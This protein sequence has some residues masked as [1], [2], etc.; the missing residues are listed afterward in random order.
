MGWFTPKMPQN[1]TP[2][3]TSGSTP[4]SST[5][6]SGGWRDRTPKAGSSASRVTVGDDQTVS[7]VT[8]GGNRRVGGWRDRG[9]PEAS[10]SV[11]AGKG[12]RVTERTSNGDIKN[13]R[14]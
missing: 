11:K 6:R 10:S 1:P 5:S 13:V 3:S 12:S 7:V 9:R 14:S 8:S 2:D 4:A